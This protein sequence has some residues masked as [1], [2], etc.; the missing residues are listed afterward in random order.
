MITDARR[1]QNTAKLRNAQDILQAL[2]H[3]LSL[4]NEEE[5][6]LGAVLGE[7]LSQ[8]AARYES[9]STQ[10][11][12]NASFLLGV[13]YRM[14]ERHQG[15][16]ELK[17]AE[18]SELRVDVGRLEE[19]VRQL[20]EDIALWTERNRYKQGVK[21]QIAGT[22]QY[23]QGQYREFFDRNLLLAKQIQDSEVMVRD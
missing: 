12:K 2:S 7:R 13:S 22:L 15:V 9:F 18:A 4:P 14:S 16:L 21:D 8:I 23:I 5:E 17:N 6:N 20:R 3:K 10:E 1:R 11:S 19:S